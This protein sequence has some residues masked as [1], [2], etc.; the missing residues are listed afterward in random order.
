MKTTPRRLLP[1]AAAA[2]FLLAASTS[3]SA[4]SHMDAPL[5]TLDDAANT[6]DVYAFVQMAATAVMPETAQPSCASVSPRS[7]WS[8]GPIGA[9]LPRK[10]CGLSGYWF[11]CF[12]P[13]LS[14]SMHL[15]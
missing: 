4:S 6:T 1:L 12:A 9:I 8:G 15:I 7:C 10:L 3:A 11:P 2:G 14:C 5:I 13:Q